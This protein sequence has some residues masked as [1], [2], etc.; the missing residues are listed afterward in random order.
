[1]SYDPEHLADVVRDLA[2]DAG[3]GVRRHVDVAEARIA[4]AWPLRVVLEELAR[5]V[6]DESSR[7][8]VNAALL[9]IHPDGDAADPRDSGR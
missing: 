7:V 1:M 4:D 3:A 9:I 8:V 5:A 2:L 6:I